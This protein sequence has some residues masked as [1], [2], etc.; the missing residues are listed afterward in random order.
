[1]C[2]NKPGYGTRFIC[3]TH[4]KSTAKTKSRDVFMRQSSKSQICLLKGE[5][6]GIVTDREAGW[7]EVWKKGIGGKEKVKPLVLCGGISELHVSSWDS[8]SKSDSATMI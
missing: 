1:M 2:W 6:L 5:G 4:I 7:F 8:Y 3:P